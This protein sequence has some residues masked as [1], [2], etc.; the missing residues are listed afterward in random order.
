MDEALALR[1][2]EMDFMADSEDL[3]YLIVAAGGPA[4]YT[5]RCPRDNHRC[6]YV[7]D[8]PAK[9]RARNERYASYGLTAAMACC[10]GEQP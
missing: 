10:R 8:D 5:D 7:H 2:S 1:G 9:V 3:D 6:L 4:L